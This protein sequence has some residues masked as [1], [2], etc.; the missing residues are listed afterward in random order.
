MSGVQKLIPV[1]TPEA[2]NAELGATLDEAGCCVVEGAADPS[3]MDSISAELA[4]FASEGAFGVGEFEG[5]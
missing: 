1:L 5:L 3:V 2:S 4:P